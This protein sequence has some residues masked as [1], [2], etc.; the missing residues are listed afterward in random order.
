[1]SSITI[2]LL[3]TPEEMSAVEELQREVWPGSE[4]DVVPAHLLITVVHNG[5]VVLGAFAEEKLVGFVFGFPGLETTPDGPRPKHCSHMAGVHPDHRDRGVAFALK[6]AQ[7]QMVRHQGLDH[8]TWT[9]DPL[10]SRNAYLNI[11]RLGAVCSRYL[12]SEYG[13]MRDGLN[14]GLPSDRFQVDWW[15]NTKRVERRLGKRARPTLKLNHLTR[16]GVRPLYTLRTGPAN[17]TLPP[18]HI[19]PIDSQLVAAEIPADFMAVKAAD[20]ALARDWR[21]FSRELFETAFAQGYIVTDFVFDRSGTASR[22]FYILTDGE[23]T[24]DSS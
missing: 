22:S 16:V 9:Y 12:R 13:D 1:M 20:F 7:W 3:E 18:E 6:R 17:L 21:F 2:R 23:S 14:A 19:P 10:L 11:A 15:I 5:G 4:T 24:L 8:I